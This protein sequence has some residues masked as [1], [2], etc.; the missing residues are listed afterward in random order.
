MSAL[1]E[2][3]SL[4]AMSRAKVEDAGAHTRR[5]LELLGE[6]RAAIVDGH[7]QAEPW[8]PP[9][10]DGALEKI[11]NDAALMSTADDLLKEYEARL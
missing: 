4:L 2:F 11:G 10:L 7:E 1:E 6:A 8:L 5:A 9:Q 3:H